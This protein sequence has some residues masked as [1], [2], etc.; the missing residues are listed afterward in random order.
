ML[1]I[2]ENPIIARYI[3][4]G[5]YFED[6]TPE[7]NSRNRALIKR[8][9]ESEK[10]LYLLKTSTCLQETEIASSLVLNLMNRDGPV[11]SLH[12]SNSYTTIILLT[13]LPNI[14]EVCLPTRWTYALEETPRSDQLLKC[15]VE[16]ANNQSLPLAGLAKLVSIIPACSGYR[17]NLTSLFLLRSIDSIKHFKA[18]YS[19][20]LSTDPVHPSYRP[21]WAFGSGK[22]VVDF[23]LAHAYLDHIILRVVLS[24]LT[25]LRTFKF[26][27]NSG[28]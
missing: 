27:F 11:E 23:E 15:I 21:R 14:T 1:N 8:F 24:R 5:N 4:R 26:G 6:C 2:A 16:R 19:R 22:K 10:F 12:I 3:V 25:E 7:D 13:L 17:S 9:R 20:G 28:W 18:A